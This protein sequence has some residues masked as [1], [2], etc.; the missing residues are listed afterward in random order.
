MVFFKFPPTPHLAWL[1]PNPARDDKVLSE[2]E[3]DA[4]L[5]GEVVIEEKVDGAN[6]GL[7]VGSGR[8]VQA[9][10]RGAYLDR[11]THPQFNPLWSW[12]AVRE[13]ELARSLGE[14]LVLFGE[15]CF[16]VHSVRYDRLPDWFLGFDVYD[17]SRRFF[18]STA[19]R[20]AL[21]GSLGLSQVPM[22][23]RGRY[24][25]PGLCAMLAS[26]RSRV[27]NGPA[28]GFYLRCED[29]HGLLARAKL[30]RTEFA[31]ALDTHWSARKLSKNRVSSV[32]EQPGRADKSQLDKS[33]LDKS[34]LDNC[35]RHPDVNRYPTR[36]R[37]RR[38]ARRPR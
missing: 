19:R 4:F 21:L 37:T 8:V 35:F 24:D 5:R 28:E 17:R 12:L 13:H 38:S 22:I 30:I 2:Q 31:Q 20:D 7:S 29:E 15:W 18:W 1:G 27:G 23:E 14:H 6:L 36:P 10:N 16:A 25:L 3:R 32:A 33:Q 11:S 26:A 34:C 9:Q